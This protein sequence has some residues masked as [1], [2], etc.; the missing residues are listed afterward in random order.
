MFSGQIL[1]GTK[2]AAAFVTV[3]IMS[4]M[5]VPAF[6]QETPTPDPTATPTPTPEPTPTPDPATTPEPTPTPDTTT[7]DVTPTPEPGEADGTTSLKPVPPGQLK[8]NGLFGD[9]VSVGSSSIVVATK[10]G[11]ITVDINAATQIKG[12]TSLADINVGDRA[13]VHLNRSP[14]STTEPDLPTPTP[15]PTPDVTATPTPEATPTPAPTVEALEDPT[16]TPTPDVVTPTPTPEGTLTPTPTPEGTLT[17]TPTPGVTPTPTPVV[18]EESFRDVVARSI[19]I[20]PSKATRGH[21]RTVV[22]GKCNAPAHARGK[23]TVLDDEGN[24]IALDCGDGETTPEGEDVILLTKGKGKSAEVRGSISPDDIDT[25]LASFGSLANDERKALLA[26][27]K[28]KRELD[29][30][31]RLQN[32]ES[33]APAHAKSKVQKARGKPSSSGEGDGEGDTPGRGNSG[34]G[35]GGSSNGGGNSGNNGGGNSGNQG[36]G[37]SGNQGGGNRNR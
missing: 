2:I 18:I 22:T 3:L 31:T 21:S 6:A 1:S 36:G 17:P 29:R 14:L 11:N 30:E 32:L 27:L 25:R 13:A 37:N 16:A 26:E 34:N 9:V 5:T 4:M 19:H 20:I 23:M 24:E 8:R 7:P 33:K 15:A 35:G 10:F 12:A 28:T